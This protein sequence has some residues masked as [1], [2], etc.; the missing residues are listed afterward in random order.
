M[1]NE[2]KR[3]IIEKALE[4]YNA[5]DEAYSRLEGLFGGAWEGFLGDA[6][7]F[8]AS[9]FLTHTALACDIGDDAL[10]WFVYE[11]RQ[12]D[13]KLE[14]YADDGRTTKVTSLKSFYKAVGI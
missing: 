5:L 9:D 11:N 4:R 2:E 7:W 12:G 14:W 13:N 8:L 6:T 3:L 1:T 10:T